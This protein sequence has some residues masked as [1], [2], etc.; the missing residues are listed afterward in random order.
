MSNQKIS[1]LL[2]LS[3]LSAPI[4]MPASAAS[5]NSAISSPIS[6]KPTTSIRA[7]LRRMK[8]QL[9]EYIRPPLAN[10]IDAPLPLTTASDQVVGIYGNILYP[11]DKERLQQ[12]RLTDWI[13]AYAIDSN[14]PY[15]LSPEETNDL[16]LYIIN[17]YPSS[18][19]SLYFF[20]R[21]QHQLNIGRS[22]ENAVDVAAQETVHRGHLYREMA[23][24]IPAWGGRCEALSAQFT[25]C[26][27]QIEETVANK[28]RFVKTHP[29]I[30]IQQQIDAISFDLIEAPFTWDMR[31]QVFK[32]MVEKV[33]ATAPNSPYFL[34]LQE[35]TPQA[36]SDLKNTLADRNLQW[37]SF[38]N[39]SGKETLQPNQEQ[40]LG[41]ATAFTST[42]ALSSDLE[43]LKVELG[44]LPTE[45]GSI[46]KILG[47]RV[48]NTH[49][50]ETFTIFTTHTD[51]M[52]QNDIYAR[53]A[54]K[55]HEF[56]TQFFQDAPNQERFVIGG[57]L[58]VF[59]DRDGDQYIAKL[60]ELFTDSQDFRETDYYAP[61]PIAWSSFVGRYDDTYLKRLSKEG[62]V[63]PSALDQI[64]VG[65]GVELQSAAREALVYNESGQLL[66]YYKDWEAYM[67]Q[68]QKGVTFSDHLFNI[69]RFK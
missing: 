30:D 47:V 12:K 55:V 61:H 10:H 45:S 35:V 33:T 64:L 62:V 29:D 40:I 8:H 6:H 59:E 21:I 20:Q 4:A 69:V 26:A 5:H 67:A 48:R 63:E 27:D 41:E 66:D 22:F 32:Q 17:R 36:L 31:T 58:N 14:T 44:D 9:P 60:R 68:L 13:E 3:M 46:R 24:K 23:Q 1:A 42:L 43:V 52:I 2:A 11:Q 15:S 7:S 19:I 54:A 34:A 39:T 37:I 18:T 57:D 28:A 16:S 25:E 50:N 65:N 56:A 38:N 53:T 51:H 49:T